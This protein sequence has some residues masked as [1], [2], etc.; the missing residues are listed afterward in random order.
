MLGGQTGGGNF[1]THTVYFSCKTSA[2]VT[3]KYYTY[4]I[5]GNIKMMCNCALTDE[6]RQSLL[7]H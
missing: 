7:H 6:T 4:L 3:E 1:L 5:F 2:C